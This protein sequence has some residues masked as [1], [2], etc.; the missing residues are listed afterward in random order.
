VTS[1]KVDIKYLLKQ[2]NTMKTAAILSLFLTSASA[3][4]PVSR[5]SSLAPLKAV[6]LDDIVG[7]GI[8][9][10][11]KV[12]DPVDMNRWLPADVAR[13]YELAN[14]RVAMLANVGWFFP[15]VVGHFQGSVDPNDP[16][17]AI[18]QSSPQWWAQF[19]L[20]CGVFEFYKYQS[21][22]NGRSYTGNGEPAVDWMGMYPADEAGRRNVEM[23]ELKNGR[24]AMLGFASYISAH[25]ISGSVPMLPDN[26]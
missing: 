10:G 9:T 21:K 18:M 25:F 2:N 14:G 17:G 5:S 22:M 4:A 24:L 20:L 6:G 7:V 16:V 15:S 1:T 13:D 26:F 8:E 12:W 3:F 19:I 11:N 23:Q